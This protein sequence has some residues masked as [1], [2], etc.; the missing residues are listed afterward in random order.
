MSE[1]LNRQGQQGPS[2][3]EIYWQAMLARQST[4]DGIFVYGVR[5]TGIYCKP[6]CP[7]RRPLRRESAAFFTTC[8]AA[9][10]EGFRACLRCRPRET[11]LA[12]DPQ[13]EMVLDVCRAIEAQA[14]R[15]PSLDD[16]SARLGVSPYHL[17]RTFKKVMGIT[18]RQYATSHRLKNFKSRIRAGEQIGSAMYEV[19]YGSS[20]RLYERASEKMGMTPAAYRRRG[21]GM[22]V[23]YTIVDCFLGRM[24]LA[25]TARGVCAVSFG[26][27]DEQ[28]SS[29]LVAEYPAANIKRGGAMLTEWV[30]SLLQH[31]EGAQPQIN[32]PLDLQ[33]TA[34]QTRVW[35]ELKRIPYG[36]TRSYAEIA[37]AIGQSKATRAVARA[38]ATNPA[39]L[40]IPCHRVVRTGDRLAGYR[41]GLE[42]K[43]KL[44]EREQ[45][46]R[47][48]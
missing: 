27:S 33:A 47:R 5:S 39:A 11:A 2:E 30:E 42:R 15:I 21:E 25:A 17:H 1:N 19:G 31:L 23:Y 43:K 48:N 40:L 26:D 6:S 22:E 45:Q 28:L 24:L 37:E 34:F 32:L 3:E 8:E 46:R 44:L 29:S 38:C 36:Q 12:R 4:F 14:D 16:I 9:E 18:P 13:V 35:E 7:S 41:W 10:A 20:S